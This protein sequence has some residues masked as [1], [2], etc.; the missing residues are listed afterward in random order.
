MGKY[1]ILT[2]NKISSSGL[3]IFQSNKYNLGKNIG[4]PDAILIRSHNLHEM[5][6]EESVKAIGRAGTGV[7][8]IPVA[9]M[10]L[11]GV[12]V[13]NTPGANAN[14]V[15]ELVIAAILIAARNLIPA[16]KFVEDI[17]VESSSISKQVEEGKKQFAGIELSG[18]TLGVVGLGAIGGAVADT[19]IK[20][21][22]NVIG[23]DP[24]L[25]IEAAWQIPTSV[26]KAAKLEYLFTNS[27]IVT[28][29]VPL[30]NS[31]K[32]LV[33]QEKISLMKKD[34]LLINFSRDEIV[35]EKAILDGIA[36]RKIQYYVN[37]FPSKLLSKN[38]K[39]ISFPHLGAS[40]KE[41]ESNSA[42]MIVRRIRDYL[43]DG[44]ITS[45]VN[46]P[47]VEMTRESKY[48]ISISN[49]NVPN[50]LGK[51]SNSLGNADINIHN[52]VNKSRGKMAY[53][54]VDVDNPVPNE[55]LS[56][57][58]SFRGVLKVRHLPL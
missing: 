10:N 56:K 7:N 45:A 11:R 30:I 26:K 29:H 22:M 15:K 27:E 13:F 36:A 23:Y 18:R 9:E 52:M 37:D 53:T 24:G 21:G 48:R 12:P 17:D 25:T 28:I 39:V 6:I 41:A 31:T 57:I 47:N 50:M 14:A 2:L 54:L 38:I 55:T 46:F 33:D 35:N 40:T 58:S 19:A 43:E 34:S 51:I 42:I 32:G 1:R 16:A 20:L 3:N 49:A 8:N 5:E 44:N 4:N